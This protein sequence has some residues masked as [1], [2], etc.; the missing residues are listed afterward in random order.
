MT[1]KIYQ[2]KI[3][4]KNISPPIWRRILIPADAT[5][6][7]LHE[8]IQLVFGWADY[9]LHEFYTEKKSGVYV[10]GKI[11]DLETL[12]GIAPWEEAPGDERKI[13][14]KDRLDGEGQRMAYTYDFGDNWEHEI[15]MEKIEMRVKGIE[16]PVCIGGKRACPPEDCHGSW[17]YMDLLEAVSDPKHEQHEEMLEW[18]GIDTPKDF[19]PDEFDIDTVNEILR[20]GY[21]AWAP[22]LV[23]VN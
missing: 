14:L 20:D 1:N 4:L 23:S 8:T 9:H 13:L 19:D 16:Y 12:D 15:L 18:L 10:D 5:F 21:E 2:I 17:G 11:T 7:D 22:Q 3:S 6:R